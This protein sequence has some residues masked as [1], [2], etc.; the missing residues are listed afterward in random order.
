MG[1]NGHG[2]STLFLPLLRVAGRPKGR[3]YS[4]PTRQVIN[5]VLVVE[6]YLGYTGQT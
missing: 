1:E 5:R 3:F 2:L 6:E 4:L